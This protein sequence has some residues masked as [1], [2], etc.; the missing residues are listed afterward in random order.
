[1]LEKK[2]KQGFFFF[3]LELLVVSNLKFGI[4]VFKVSL[5]CSFNTYL[6]GTY[7]VQGIGGEHKSLN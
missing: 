5:G 2:Q 3:F 7:H 1:M 4:I 6:M